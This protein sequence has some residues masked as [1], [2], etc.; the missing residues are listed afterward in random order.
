MSLLQ[1]LFNHLAPSPPDMHPD[2]GKK[3][4]L[5]KL[6][7]HKPSSP[8]D[9]EQSAQGPSRGP[10]PGKDWVGLLGSE[11]RLGLGVLS[12]AQL[13]PSLH[14]PVGASPGTK[15][16]F[17]YLSLGG[18]SLKKDFTDYKW[19]KKKK[20]YSKYK[21]HKNKPKFSKILTPNLKG[22]GPIIGLHLPSCPQSIP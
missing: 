15:H 3:G 6:R 5:W 4:L 14:L 10:L 18:F 20:H 16:Q 19:D 21:W 11:R 9:H 2:Q 13:C 12:P 17:L 7:L 8:P 1:V 22:R